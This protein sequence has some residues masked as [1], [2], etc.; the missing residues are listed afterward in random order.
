MG[1]TASTTKHSAHLCAALTP[2]LELLDKD[3]P[4]EAKTYADHLRESV[5][6]GRCPDV[7]DHFSRDSQTLA[8]LCGRVAKSFRGHA[9]LHDKYLPGC[10][11]LFSNLLLA[12]RQASA[13]GE[14][15]GVDCLEHA[16]CF[17][18]SRGACCVYELSPAFVRDVL[19]PNLKAL[20]ARARQ[21]WFVRA[22]AST[23]SR[24]AAAEFLLP[25]LDVSEEEWIALGRRLS[26]THAS[27]SCPTWLKLAQFEKYPN[28]WA[29]AMMEVRA[30]NSQVCLPGTVL[31]FLAMG[32]TSLPRHRSTTSP[33][34][35]K[36][37]CSEHARAYGT[38][39]ELAGKTVHAFPNPS[40]AM[41]DRVLVGLSASRFIGFVAEV[42][43]KG[44]ERDG[45][46]EDGLVVRVQ[47]NL[48]KDNSVKVDMNVKVTAAS[49]ERTMPPPP[50]PP[51]HSKLTAKPC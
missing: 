23:D 8:L 35:L 47:E 12:L 30:E 5:L 26:S 2:L 41:G 20:S 33:A 6:A 48:K 7:T 3:Y 21:E 11:P 4:E 10:A 9:W 16:W 1:C 25:V 51:C 42:W 17:V 32:A 29:R 46:K 44:N 27:L 14:E 24:H 34:L 22:C 38:Y 40:H 15:H 43:F 31:T 36:L 18:G 13:S 39:R 19:G 49:I 50:L 37:S 28:E 45:F